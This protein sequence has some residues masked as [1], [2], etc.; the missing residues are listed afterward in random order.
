MRRGKSTTLSKVLL[1]LCT[2]TVM[3][4]NQFGCYCTA[5]WCSTF[6]DA[7]NPSI[8]TGVVSIL[9]GL[10]N[11]TF[12]IINTG[13]DSA[14]ASGSASFTGSSSSSDPNSP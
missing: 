6:R 10:V 13:S 3:S 8:E 11:G 9:T 14:S 7:A 12:A 1:V 5:D 4:V 2:L